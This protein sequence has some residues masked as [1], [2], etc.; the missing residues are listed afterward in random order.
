MTHTSPND[1]GNFARGPEYF[2]GYQSDAFDALWEEIRTEA[3]PEA[4]NALQRDAQQYLADHA[5]MGFLFQL[6]KVTVA[7]AGIEGLWTDAPVT[8]APMKDVH[9]AD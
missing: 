9:W 6:P 2:Y 5:V 3:D 1:L 8:F 4:R 7:R